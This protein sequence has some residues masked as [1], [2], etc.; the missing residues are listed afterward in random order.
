[1]KN[2]EADWP[3]EGSLGCDQSHGKV[4]FLCLQCASA[5]ANLFWKFCEFMVCPHKG[6][7][8][9]H[10][11]GE[12]SKQSKEN[13]APFPLNLLWHHQK[14]CLCLTLHAMFHDFLL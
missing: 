8:S 7:L 13:I 4:T 6:Q 11:Q 2:G 12:S 1:M 5:G 3:N 14:F 10:A 9:E